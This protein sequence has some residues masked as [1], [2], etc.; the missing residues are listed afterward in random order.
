VSN[1][2]DTVSHPHKLPLLQALV[3]G[4]AAATPY[5][6]KAMTYAIDR[7]PRLEVDAGQVFEKKTVPP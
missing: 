2:A 1:A 5:V 7:C 6:Q 4:I 3:G